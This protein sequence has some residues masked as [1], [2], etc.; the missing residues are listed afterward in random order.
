MNNESSNPELP[1][2]V[3]LGTPG[4]LPNLHID[5]DPSDPAAL[6]FASGI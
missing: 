4:P 5:L 1:K 3:L 6:L 2:E